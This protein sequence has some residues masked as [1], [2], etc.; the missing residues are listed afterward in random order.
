[1]SDSGGV[2]T[3]SIRRVVVSRYG[4]P[5]ELRLVQD[6]AP[7]PARGEVR[8]RT[9]AAGV[10]FPDVLIREGTYPGGP[11]PPFTPGYDLVGVVDAL[12]PAAA[13]FDLGEVV[14]AITVVGG[15]ADA[16]CVP[17]QHLARV[18]AQVDPAEAVCLAFNY[19]TAYQLLTRAARVRPG[20]RVLVHGGAGGVGSA[21]LELAAVAKLEAYAT[22]SGTGGK[23]VAELGATPIDYR[24][25]DFVRR[26][27]A[28]TGDGADVV[29][30]GIGGTVALRS[31]RALAPGGRLVMYGHYA[32]L[33]GG[34]RDTRKVAIFYAAGALAFAANLLPGRRVLAYQSAKTRDRHPDWY[35]T[36]LAALFRLLADGHLHPLIAG[37]LP[38]TEVRHAHELLARGGVH[39]KLV[40]I[41]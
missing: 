13:G 36:D 7:Q 28:L 27:H 4:G 3:G 1:M 16:V 32:T 5:E 26:I 40:L 6:A 25:E 18:P 30:D 33:V 35:R 31:V 29:L 12:G 34:R 21:A 37:R 23:V 41:P 38:L 2:A 14:A 9:L 11:P 20:E 17:Q 19:I 24:G 22:A 15:Y 10:S 39:G 8:V